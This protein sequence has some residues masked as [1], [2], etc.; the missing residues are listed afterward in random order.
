MKLNWLESKVVSMLFFWS[1]VV[2]L[3]CFCVGLSFVV[4]WVRNFLNSSSAN[5]ALGN[6]FAAL[7]VLTIPCALIISLGMAIFC[8]FTDRAAVGAKAVWFLLFFVTWPIGSM[9]YYFA[10]YR[11]FIKRQRAGDAPSPRVVS[12]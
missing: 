5:N 7:V 10:T 3:S 8:G 4:P 9:V 6:L 2:C 12:A 11:G 1:V